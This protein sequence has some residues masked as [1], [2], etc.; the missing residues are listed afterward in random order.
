MVQLI[1]TTVHKYVAV[2]YKFL[3]LYHSISHRVS[4]TSKHTPHP[5]FFCLLLPVRLSCWLSFPPLSFPFLI[6]F[7]PF[8]FSLIYLKL[9][10]NWISSSFQSFFHIS[11]LS[12]LNSLNQLHIFGHYIQ[13][14]PQNTHSLYSLSSQYLFPSS[15]FPY[16]TKPRTPSPT[17]NLYRFSFLK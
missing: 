15:I 10:I 8:S 14:I 4:H 12:F 2:Q 17:P 3:I 7:F 16:L 6:S 11:S 5:L 13:S 1:A 9:Y